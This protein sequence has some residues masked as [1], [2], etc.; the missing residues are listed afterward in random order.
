MALY[1]H[2]WGR[3]QRFSV[4]VRESIEQPSTGSD[5]VGHRGAWSGHVNS[6]VAYSI[7][8]GIP[9]FRHFSYVLT[10]SLLPILCKYVSNEQ[11]W[12][13]LC[14]KCFLQ[15]FPKQVSVHYRNLG[16][17]NLFYHSQTIR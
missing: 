17:R 6:G 10:N 8:Y 1:L 12:L 2:F 9:C 16:I 4:G 11:P 7:V 5:Q 15:F 14:L 13:I 3:K